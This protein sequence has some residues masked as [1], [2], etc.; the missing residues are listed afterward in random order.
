MFAFHI[1]SGKFYQDEELIGSGYSGQPPHVGVVA[2]INLENKGPIPLGNYTVGAAFTHPLLG[3]LTMRL[4]PYPSNV[5]YGRSHFCI[6]GDSAAHPGYA[7]DGCVILDHNLR[8]IV[9]T[10]LAYDRILIVCS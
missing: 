5:M 4:T 3:P 9:A 10:A 1:S 8:Q 6:H 2:D 7:S